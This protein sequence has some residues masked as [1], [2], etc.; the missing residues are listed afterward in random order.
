MKGGTPM[1]MP[2]LEQV[3]EQA[4]GLSPEDRRR[5]R[6]LLAHEQAGESDEERAFWDELVS[7]GLATRPRGITDYTAYRNRKLATVTGRPVS[8]TLIEERR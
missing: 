6:E 3:L 7:E 1:D 5:L 4:K 2:T 8:E